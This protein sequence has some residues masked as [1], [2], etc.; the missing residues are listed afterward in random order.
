[1]N[2]REFLLVC[3]HESGDPSA[4]DFVL[5]HIWRRGPEY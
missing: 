3:S 1:M 2:R 4:L 5:A